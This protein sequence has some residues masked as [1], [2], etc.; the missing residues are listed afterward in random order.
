MRLSRAALEKAIPSAAIFASFFFLFS[1]RLNFW[2]QKRV[3]FEFRSASLWRFPRRPLRVRVVI[4]R[5]RIFAQKAK[6]PTRG[7]KTSCPLSSYPLPKSEKNKKDFFFSLS[8]NRSLCV[9]ISFFFFA[10]AHLLLF[11]HRNTG[12]QQQPQQ[13]QRGA[14]QIR[15]ARVAGVEIPNNKRA[16]TALTYIFGIGPT[17]AKAVMAAT[18]LENKR[19]RELSEEELTI[20]REEVDKYKNE[21]QLRS[22]ISLNIKRLKEIQCYRGKRHINNLPCRGQRSKTNART[23]KGKVKTVAG[24]KK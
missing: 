4:A 12:R 22:M 15:A 14:L 16:E 21:G 23:R 9:H 24:K 8:L 2:E 11:T 17:T 1:A 19:V 10:V 20:L 13:P 5:E 7:I 3:A 18:G 6:K